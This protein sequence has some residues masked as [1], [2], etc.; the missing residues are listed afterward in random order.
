MVALCFCTSA[1]GCDEAHGGDVRLSD[2]GKLRPREVSLRSCKSLG[3]LTSFKLLDIA[4]PLG[5]SEL[6]NLDLWTLS[7]AAEVEGSAPRAQEK[8]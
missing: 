4:E 2:L 7:R 6:E 8:P 3:T 1:S 5:S